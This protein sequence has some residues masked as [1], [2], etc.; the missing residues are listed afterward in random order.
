MHNI[1]KMVRQTPTIELNKNQVNVITNV[2]F[3]KFSLP[4]HLKEFE[5]STR[6]L[7]IPARSKYL[8]DNI[9]TGDVGEDTLFYK[10]KDDFSPGLGIDT[11][12]IVRVGGINKT[13][14]SNEEFLDNLVV[15]GVVDKEVLQVFTLV[16]ILRIARCIS[17]DFRETI[18]KDNVWFLSKQFGT[19]SYYGNSYSLVEYYEDLANT[20]LNMFRKKELT[21]ANIKEITTA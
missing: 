19:K 2:E 11:R 5:V 18:A 21:S 10:L 20:A 9:I 17:K 7:G 16:N 8:L 3:P 1:K 14:T 15:D 12:F 6:K 4:E 13:Y